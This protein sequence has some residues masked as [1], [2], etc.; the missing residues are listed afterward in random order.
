MVLSDYCNG[1]QEIIKMKNVMKNVFIYIFTILL[2]IIVVSIFVT[3]EQIDLLK[4]I[5]IFKIS[6]SVFIALTIFSVSGY[7]FSYLLN[8]T[9]GVKL[10]IIDR[11][12]FPISRN[13]WS[14]LIPFQGSFAYTLVF[15]KF[16]YNVKLIDGFTINLYLIIYNF[17]FTGLIG[18]YHSIQPGKAS[19]LFFVISVSFVIF[20]M[21]LILSNRMLKNVN[22]PEYG[23]LNILFGIL[24][25]VSLSVVTLLNNIEFTISNFI[26]YLIHTFVTTV[27]FYWTI[28]IF[29]FNIDL[30]TV[31]FLALILKTSLIFRLTPGNLGVEQLLYGGIFAL[32][33]YDPKI[34][35]L[36]SL[37]HKSITILL[38]FSI[39]LLFTFIN[40]KYFSL[41]NIINSVK[42]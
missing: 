42:K 39:G 33:N 38:S 6:V 12:T 19:L 36:I 14:Y 30:I 18:I 40:H 1:P 41:S 13:L 4:N 20:P 17:F 27:W 29:D 7:Q 11:I 25:K 5:S 35:V 15:N 3:E 37:F 16:K 24:Q 23:F 26:F 34:G 32:L 21:V 9:T 28:Y 2:I 31:I 10:N 8:R 22:R